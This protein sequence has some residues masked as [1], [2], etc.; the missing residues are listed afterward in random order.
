MPVFLNLFLHYILLIFQVDENYWG[1]GAKRYVCPQ[2]FHWGDD[3][4]PPPPPRI[5]ASAIQTLERLST[6]D[7]ITKHKQNEGKKIPF[8]ISFLSFISFHSFFKKRMERN[9]RQKRTRVMKNKQTLNK[10]ERN[11]TKQEIKER[12]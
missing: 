1:G 5:D 9:E 3:C 6:T 10:I 8:L 11:K 7:W 2:Y 4:P 12:I